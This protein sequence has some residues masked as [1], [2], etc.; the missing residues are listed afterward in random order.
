MPDAGASLEVRFTE[1][2]P[3]I[4]DSDGDVFKT[5]MRMSNNPLQLD[6]NASVPF[7]PE[8]PMTKDLVRP[9]DR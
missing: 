1:R 7:K 4:T 3:T 6:R 5:N 9:H 8:F 2:L